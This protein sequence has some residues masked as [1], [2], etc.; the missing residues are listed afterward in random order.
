MKKT[1]A[2]VKVARPGKNK[3]TAAK[4]RPTAA[5]VDVTVDVDAITNLESLP[6]ILTLPEISGIYRLS[7]PTIRKML[8]AGTFRPRQFDK[9]PYRWRR[10]DVITDLARRRDEK[11]RA[12]GFAA[13][14]RQARATLDSDQSANA[15]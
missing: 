9:Y 14:R 1:A 7:I 13:R 5:T 11:R 12:H 10:A 15:R 8:Q 6:V 3:P 2:A 4:V